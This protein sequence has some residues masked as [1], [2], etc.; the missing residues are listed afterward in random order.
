MFVAILLVLIF[1]GLSGLH[2]YWV[3]GGAG[4]LSGFVPEIGGRPAFEPGRLATATVAVLLLLAAAICAS[5]A[6][7]LGVP[8]FAFA[9]MGVLVLLVL[10]ALRAVGEFNLVGFFKRVRDTQFGR[11]DTWLYSPVCL[12]LSVLCGALLYSTK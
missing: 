4:D 3:I 12:A 6:E 10:F 5:Q 8:R 11:R 1:I 2:W 9:R 7:L